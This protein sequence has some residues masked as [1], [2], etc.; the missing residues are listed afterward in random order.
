MKREEC[1]IKFWVPVN[2]FIL[3]KKGKDRK[4]MLKRYNKNCKYSWRMIYIN[5]K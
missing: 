2:K 5:Y 1:Q 4:C 3:Y